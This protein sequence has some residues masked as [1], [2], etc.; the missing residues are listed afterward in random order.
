M[1]ALNEYDLK[2]LDALQLSL[3]IAYQA[4]SNL[5]G[6]DSNSNLMIMK[7]AD[8][9]SAARKEAEEELAL[10]ENGILLEVDGNECTLAEFI[11][12]NMQARDVNHITRKDV[13]R[14]K[15]LREG[16]STHIGLTNVKRII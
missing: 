8:R 5:N 6:K 3:A 15:A 14:V 7:W 2:E 4:N 10:Q 1:K 13:D 16:E 11:Q 9:V 12:T